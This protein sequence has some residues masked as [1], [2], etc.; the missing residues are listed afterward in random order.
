[1]KIAISLLCHNDEY[2]LKPCLDSLFN[3]D[4]KNHE[5]KL[6]CYDNA[7]EQGM[8]DYLNSLNINKHIFSS[9]TND[10]IVIPRIKNY[11]NI[12]N[13]DFDFLLELH[14]DMIFPKIWIDPLFN[15]FDEQTGI[16]EP[17]IYIPNKRIISAE[18]F[19]QIVE[20]LRT[21]VIYSKCRQNHPWLIN[22]KILDL[23]DGYYDPAYSPHECEDDD[24]VYRV[25]KNNFKIKTTGQSWVVHYGGMIRHYLLPSCLSEHVAYFVAKNK[26]SFEDFVKMFDNHPA[27]RE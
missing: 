3:S 12:K 23:I 24:L 20:N 10:G 1:M 11:E 14:S 18:E 25:L 27:K 2:L 21:N 26:I 5:F 8:K 4:L 17:H 7:S 19:E 15:I 22:L 6:F 9:E 13:E 16:L